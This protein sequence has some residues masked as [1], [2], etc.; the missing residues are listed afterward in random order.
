MEKLFSF[1]SYFS[2]TKKESSQK[3]YKQKMV[4]AFIKNYELNKILIKIYSLEKIFV[5]EDLILFVNE[6]RSRSKRQKD[7]NIDEEGSG[8]YQCN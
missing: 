7:L 2:T 1:C 3:N 6:P 4:S 5:D 8:S